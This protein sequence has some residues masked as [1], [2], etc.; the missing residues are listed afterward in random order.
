VLSSFDVQSVWRKA[1]EVGI[2]VRRE[3]GRNNAAAKVVME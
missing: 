2:E 3:E 1:S